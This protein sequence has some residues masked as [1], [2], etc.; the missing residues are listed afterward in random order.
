MWGC[1]NLV[2]GQK[3][4][5]ANFLL[6]KEKFPSQE[7]LVWTSRIGVFLRERF[8]VSRVLQ[9]EEP[10]VKKKWSL[11]TAWKKTVKSK[12]LKNAWW[13]GEGPAYGGRAGCPSLGKGEGELNRKFIRQHT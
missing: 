8:K 11:G 10:L 5:K 9:R 13:E 1:D 6:W 2:V 4:A 7:A 12:D 3:Q